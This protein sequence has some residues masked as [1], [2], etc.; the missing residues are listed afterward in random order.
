MNGWV[1]EH[2]A[3]VL[4]LALALPTFLT[5]YTT[6]KVLLSVDALNTSMVEARKDIQHTNKTLEIIQTE[7]GK[8]RSDIEDLKIRIALIERDRQSR[9]K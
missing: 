1:K 9:G 7:Q 5:Q 8:H 4:G 2:I 6:N 3:W